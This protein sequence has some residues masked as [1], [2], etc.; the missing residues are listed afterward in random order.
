MSQGESLAD[1]AVRVLAKLKDMNDDVTN[2]DEDRHVL[3]E[4]KRIADEQLSSALRDT[5][6][7]IYLADNV[8]ELRGLK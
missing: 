4:I 5:E 6:R 1:R 7:L 3:R 8:R 2:D